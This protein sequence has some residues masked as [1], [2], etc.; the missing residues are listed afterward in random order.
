MPA[1]LKRRGNRLVAGELEARWNEALARVEKI[2]SDLAN[3]DTDCIDLDSED[4]QRMLDLGVN[5]PRLWKHPAAS[6]ELKKRVP[7]DSVLRWTRTPVAS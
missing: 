7:E 2:E 6:V 5:L 1:R 3:S 4:R